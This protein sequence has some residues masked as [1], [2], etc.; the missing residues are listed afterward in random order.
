MDSN[1]SQTLTAREEVTACHTGP[2][3]DDTRECC[4]QAGPVRGRQALQR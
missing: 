3:R 4:E 1:L 2:H